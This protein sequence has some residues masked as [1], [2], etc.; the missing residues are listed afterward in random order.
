METPTTAFIAG[1]QLRCLHCDHDQFFTCMRRLTTAEF[2][3]LD[4][5]WSDRAAQTYVCSRCGRVEWFIPRA[6]EVIMDSTEGDFNCLECG[7]VIG[8]GRTD[9]PKC[10]WS[11]ASR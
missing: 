1:K 5:I 11:Y 6:A 2:G 10:G 7:E 8:D 3:F 9:C 4:L